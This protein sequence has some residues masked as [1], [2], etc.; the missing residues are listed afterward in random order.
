MDPMQGSIMN[1]SMLPIS[2]FAFAPGIFAS[3]HEGEDFLSSLDSDTRDYVIKHTD[4]FRTKQDIVD[5]I[6][7]L[8]GKS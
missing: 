8:H 7:R 2:G 5:C 1:S 6:N 3:D 4:E